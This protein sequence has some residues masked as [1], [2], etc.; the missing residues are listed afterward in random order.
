M[1]KLLFCMITFSLLACVRRD[2]VTDAPQ[3]DKHFLMDI[4]AAYEN[5][6]KIYLSEFATNITYIP[7]ETKSESLI[8]NIRQILFSD[9]Y[10]FVSQFRSLHQFTRDGKFI[11]QIGA[12]GR[13]PEEFAQVANISLNLD[14]EVIYI[15]AGN[16]QKTLLFDFNGTF[17]KSFKLSLPSARTLSFGQDGFVT[18]YPDVPLEH[19]I[20]DYLL[21]FSDSSGNFLKKV[22][23]RDKIT[24]THF[25][26][27]GQ[28]N[29]YNLGEDIYF[30]DLHNDTIFKVLYDSLVP[31]I[32]LDFGKYK[33]D[34]NTET[35]TENAK[36]LES[37]LLVY[38]VV[39][40]N[41]HAYLR[42]SH[43]Y[44]GR[45][46]TGWYDKANRELKI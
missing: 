45:Q 11:R 5:P 38:N 10:I 16:P 26:G 23:R 31:H 15:H 19:D 34:K 9:D 22:E 37:A 42:M 41:D 18:Y 12:V 40:T 13:G 43:G 20:C 2:K 28:H 35:T 3:E 17:I 39:E 25:I 4:E 33:L 32:I 29:L 36:A 44:G 14:G 6:Q 1:K 30:K 7:L 24:A 27:L 8:S 46:I 21:Y